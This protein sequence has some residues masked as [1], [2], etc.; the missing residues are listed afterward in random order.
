MLV[1]Y[2]QNEFGVW[3]VFLPNN[4]DGSSPIPHG[5]RVKVFFTAWSVFFFGLA[6][7][8]NWLMMLWPY[9]GENGYPIRNKGFN[10]CLD[11]VLRAGPRSNTLW[12]DLLWSSWRGLHFPCSVLIILNFSLFFTLCWQFFSCENMFVS[13][14]KP[15]SVFEP[16][17]FVVG[18]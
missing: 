14:V 7:L 10:S 8:Q 5:S 13:L 11:Q 4:A 1:T 17:L 16:I 18:S 12:W 15:P 6:H 9:I 3:E 2:F